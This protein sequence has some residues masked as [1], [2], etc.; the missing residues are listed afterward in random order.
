[1]WPLVHPVAM[2]WPRV[3]MRVLRC[4]LSG[5]MKGDSMEMVL[6]YSRMNSRK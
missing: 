3:R 5:T 4:L 2:F 1:M 6:H